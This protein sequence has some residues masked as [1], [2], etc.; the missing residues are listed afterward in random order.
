MI[1]T[2]NKI[3]YDTQRAQ[4]TAIFFVMVCRGACFILKCHE[5]QL[6]S[7]VSCIL[8]RAPDTA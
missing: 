4:K 7:R 5:K 2:K 1:H 3:V 6:Q 8:T